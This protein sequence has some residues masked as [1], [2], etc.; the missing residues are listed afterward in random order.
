MWA[1]GWGEQKVECRDGL[2]PSG[3]GGRPHCHTFTQQK[4]LGYQSSYQVLSE[5]IYRALAQLRWPKS[6]SSLRGSKAGCPASSSV[7]A[8]AP[9][10]PPEWQDAV[11]AKVGDHQAGSGCSRLKK[12]LAMKENTLS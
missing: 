6:C 12:L 10:L 7:A 8:A 3:G 9:E 4:S 11:G 5:G 1:R 2:R